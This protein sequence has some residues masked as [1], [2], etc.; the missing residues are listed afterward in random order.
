MKNE[1]QL[2]MECCALFAS[3]DVQELQ[4]LEEKSKRKSFARGEIIYQGRHFQHCLGVVLDGEAIVRKEHGPTLNLLQVGDCFGAAALFAPL[5]EYVS[6]VEARTPCTI[7]FVPDLVL[8]ELFL[9][10]PQVAMQYIRFLSGRIQFL[11]HK[12]DSFTQPSV[13]QTVQQWLLHHCG[14]DGTVQVQG[15][16][17]RLA[18]VLNVSRASLYRCLTQMEQQGLLHKEGDRIYLYG[19]QRIINAPDMIGEQMGREN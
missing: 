4:W 6:T 7:A 16:Y 1:K 12:I 5:N 15:G 9:G 13:Q 19:K 11:N 14:M 18:R 8:E 17:A 3:L 2:G 10:C